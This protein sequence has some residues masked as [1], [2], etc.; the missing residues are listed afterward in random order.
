MNDSTK[1]E[2]MNDMIEAMYNNDMIPL[3]CDVERISLTNLLHPL[4]F[5]IGQTTQ[6][7]ASAWHPSQIRKAGQNFYR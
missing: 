1:D 2:V 6:L 5:R 7:P 4:Y 3:L